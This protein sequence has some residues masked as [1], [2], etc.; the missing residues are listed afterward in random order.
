MLGD[1]S[2][3]LL[4]RVETATGQS[5]LCAARSRNGLDGWVID[6]TPTFVSDPSRPEEVWGVEDPRITFVPELGKYA[7]TYTAFGETGPGVALALT[8]DFRTFERYGVVMPPD[9]KDAALLPHRI[10][11]AWAMIHRPMTG[12][13]ADIWI[14]YSPDLRNWGS[15]EIVLR[16]HRGSRWDA[17]KIGLSPP[18]LET[19][20]GWLML[21]HGVRRTASGSIYRVGAA[22]LDL[23]E[24]TRCIRRG[25]SWL[26]GPEAPYEAL[27]DVPQVVF[28]CGMTRPDED[29][30]A[31]YYG[32]ADTCIGV[33]H[34]SLGRLLAWLEREPPDEREP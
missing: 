34:A 15:H 33:A 14:S 32:A 29:T 22:L 4:C 9:D 17:Y 20:A 10:H 25:S 11:G 7:V 24:P 23:D 21:Y 12:T 19:S 27:G 28:P 6:K 8:S 13:R 5:H 16:A 31:L 1:G 3:L 30:L 26:F 2:T 18:L